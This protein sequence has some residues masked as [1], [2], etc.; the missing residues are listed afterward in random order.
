MICLFV[1]LSVVARRRDQGRSGIRRLQSVLYG[2]RASRAAERHI[3]YVRAVS[4]RVNYRFGNIALQKYTRRLTGFYSH[5]FYV[6]RNAYRADFVIRRRDN[7]RDVRAVSVVVHRVAA[8]EAFVAYRRT[9]VNVVYISVAVVVY[10]VTG[11][12][13]GVYPHIGFQIGVSIVYARI[14][15][16]N[17]N[18]RIS[19]S[20]NAFTFKPTPGL[21]N[22]A[23]GQIPL[24]FHLNIA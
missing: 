23:G 11:N 24:V 4:I 14:D 19:T 9:T 6:I 15:Y 1:R 10:S 21:L 7:A 22:I 3:Y 8:M 2:Y 5:Y 18:G 13:V 12:F 17:R 16:R 20:R